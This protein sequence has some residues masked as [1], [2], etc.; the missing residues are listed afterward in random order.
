MV[1]FA[2]SV[3]LVAILVLSSFVARP[4]R[5]ADAQVFNCQTFLVQVAAQIALITDPS[6]PNNLDG[7]DD[8]GI[9]CKELPC[10]CNY[11]VVQ[12]AVGDYVPP[13]P[14]PQ[15]TTPAIPTPVLAS[16]QVPVIA[17]V[18]QA[19]TSIATAVPATPAATTQGFITPP[20]TGSA[21]LLEL[22]FN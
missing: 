12:A 11:E 14:T 17:T 2:L 3:S 19:A 13:T 9:A 15:P 4:R 10:P 8:D 6:D 18:A 22:R 21:G 20:S 7:P 5:V 16:T 1:R